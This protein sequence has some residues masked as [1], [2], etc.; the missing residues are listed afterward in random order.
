MKT[1]KIVALILA[2]I[3]ILPVSALAANDNFVS[4]PS[5]NQAPVVEE[6]KSDKEDFA[7]DIVITAFAEKEELGEEEKKVLTEAYDKIV[8]VE[9]ITTLAENLSQKVEDLG[10][11]KEDVAVSDIFD[12]KVVDNNNN[13]IADHGKLTITLTA[14]ALENFVALLHYKNNVWNVVESAEI[15]D[16]KLEFSVDDLSPFAIVVEAKDEETT[17]T[18]ENVAGTTEGETTGAED[19]TKDTEKTDNTEKDNNLVLI[20]CIAAAVV[21]VLVI[22]VAAGKKKKK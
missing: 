8:E 6:V 17:E 13:I 7:G 5:K 12:I 15:K 16:G 14:E 4:S 3:M 19:T 22:I 9:D 20:L 21:V 2:I 11:N 10:V 1:S 18:T